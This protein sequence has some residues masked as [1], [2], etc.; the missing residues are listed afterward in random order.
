MTQPEVRAPFGRLLTA[1][2][3]PFTPTASSTWSG[4]AAL[5]DPPRRRAAQRRA[6]GQRYDGGVAHHQRRGEGTAA[7]GGGRGGRRPG[8]G[9]RGGRHERHPHTGQLARAAEK[10]GADGLLVVDAVLQQAAAGGA[11]RAF[12][13][14]RRRDRAAGRC[15][16]TSP[17]APA[18]RSPPRLW[19]ASPSTRGSWRSRT[20][21]A[22]STAAPGCWPAP[23]LAYYS[24]DDKVT[25]P[26][27][28][29]GAVGV[30]GVP[31]TWS[32]SR[33]GD[34]RGVRGR[35]RRPGRWRCTAS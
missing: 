11:R 23:E 28:S 10:A 14:G 15:S 24:G 6:G 5:G 29:V 12:R 30:V 18:C 19:S 33:P 9:G 17:A 13:R 16:T 8:R 21:R 20:P 22:T 4:A 1:M 31:P 35:R 25:L 32:A 2:V 27:L 3:T 7:A 34:D 26:L